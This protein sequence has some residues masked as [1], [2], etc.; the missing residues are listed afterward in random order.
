MQVME[1]AM[2]EL[3]TVKET[4]EVLGVKPS[5]VRA[6][7]HRRENLEVVKVGRAV[8]IPETAVKRFIRENTRQPISKDYLKGQQ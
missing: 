2:A 1:F 7:I 8:R 5:T 6:W 3:L 4:A